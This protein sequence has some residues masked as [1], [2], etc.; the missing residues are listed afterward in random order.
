[1][2]LRSAV[3]TTE[4]WYTSPARSSAAE[5]TAMMTAAAAAAAVTIATTAAGFAI[6]LDRRT[7]LVSNDRHVYTPRY[8]HSLSLLREKKV[9]R[10]F[11]ATPI[12]YQIVT[13]LSLPPCFF[14][15]RTA[16]FATW[17]TM[18][19]ISTRAPFVSSKCALKT[20]DPSDPSLSRTISS[21][22]K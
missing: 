1:M 16:A 12:P 4:I 3:H 15:R 19:L 2:R 6:R 10:S 8:H 7:T 18:N 11:N 5:T 9:L 13:N 17:R 14:P 21:I 22:S 20:A